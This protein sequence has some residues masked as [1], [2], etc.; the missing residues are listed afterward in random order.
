[1]PE[2]AAAVSEDAVSVDDE[3]VSDEEVSEDD[4]DVSDEAVEPQPA[5]RL[6]VMA[7]AIRRARIFFFISLLL[8]C[9]FPA[10]KKEDT[11]SE[12][13]SVLFATQE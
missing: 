9:F 10:T 6:A 5:T 1:M 2:P 11:R 8:T 3:A 12:N 4:D 13:R 7:A